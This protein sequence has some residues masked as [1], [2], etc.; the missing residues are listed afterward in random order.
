MQC[1]ACG[2]LA[3]Y[4]S[5][6]A[7]AAYCSRKCAAGEPEAIGPRVKSEPRR[8]LPPAQ[9]A[10]GQPTEADIKRADQQIFAAYRAAKKWLLLALTSEDLQAAFDAK[11]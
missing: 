10:P 4:V 7:L 3:H 9:A 1:S 2:E 8:A 6:S 5:L 11:K